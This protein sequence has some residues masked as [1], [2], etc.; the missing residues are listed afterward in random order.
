MSTTS[1]TDDR[2][3]NPPGIVGLRQGAAVVVSL[4]PFVKPIV[5]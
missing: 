2:V 3:V 5:E 4:R 1:T